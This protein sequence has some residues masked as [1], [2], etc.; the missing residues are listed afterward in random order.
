MNILAY[1]LIVF[2]LTYYR[3]FLTDNVKFVHKFK[4]SLFEKHLPSYGLSFEPYVVAN[5]T[6]TFYRKKLTQELTNYRDVVLYTLNNQTFQCDYNAINYTKSD[7]NR[8]D[9][10]SV[11]S[12]EYLAPEEL[13]RYTAYAKDLLKNYEEFCI[14]IMHNFN[15]S[16]LF[17][18]I[19]L[20]EEKDEKE[21]SEKFVPSKKLV[22]L[23][24]LAALFM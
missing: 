9:S 4:A 10:G 8:I 12:V 21:V 14:K 6:V 19:E 18:G 16:L 13:Q 7:E 2:F 24:K 11:T 17:P 23:E 3:A 22:E 20:Y 15:S 5:K 1:T